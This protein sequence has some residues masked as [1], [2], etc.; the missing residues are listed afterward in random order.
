[1]SMTFKKNILIIITWS[2]NERL[3]VYSFSKQY[4]LVWE[5]FK[6][7]IIYMYKYSVS[8]NLSGFGESGI[9]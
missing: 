9:K 2:Y 5:P 8:L 7:H 3:L 4:L 6:S 1:M